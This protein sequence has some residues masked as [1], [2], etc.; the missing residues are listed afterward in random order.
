MFIK[1]NRIKEV[2]QMSD[3]IITVKN[4]EEPTLPQTIE[5]FI[6]SVTGGDT[7]LTEER[8]NRDLPV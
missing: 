8:R 4:V 3:L 7:I 5:E 6:R 2:K 1:T